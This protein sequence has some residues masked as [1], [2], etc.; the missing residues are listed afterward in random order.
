MES[1]IA[2]I[3]NYAKKKIAILLIGGSNAGSLRNRIISV[4]VE[5]VKPVLAE[6]AVVGSHVHKSDSF[7]A[8]VGPRARFTH[9]SIVVV[10]D[11]FDQL[12]VNGNTVIGAF[13]CVTWRGDN[14]ERARK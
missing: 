6:N 9:T 7:A 10:K 14:L 1:R 4:S 2:S 11:C 5:Q 13:G 3:I 12:N 8:R